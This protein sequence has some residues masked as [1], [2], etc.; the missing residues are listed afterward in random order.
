[1]NDK[2]GQFCEPIFTMRQNCLCDSETR[3]LFSW[4]ICSARVKCLNFAQQNRPI[5]ETLICDWSVVLVS[6][7]NITIG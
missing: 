5:F 4:V 7:D 6:V 2:I 1:M 3:Q